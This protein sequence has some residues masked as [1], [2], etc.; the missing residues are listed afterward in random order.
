LQ[1]Q[2]EGTENRINVARDRFNKAV[3]PYNNRIKGIPFVFVA[4]LL[5]FNEMDYYKSDPESKTAPK[6]EF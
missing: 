3:N 4:K 2:L 1:S 5:G 6:V